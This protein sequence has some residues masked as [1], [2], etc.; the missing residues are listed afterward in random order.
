MS[1]YI[2]GGM[3]LL[4]QK[5][6][7]QKKNNCW[8][9]VYIKEGIGMYLLGTSLRTL[10]KGDMM[11]L[12]P[13]VYYSFES[14]DLGDEYNENIK[15]HVMRFDEDWLNDLIKVFPMM[16]AT[17]LRIKEIR[18]PLAVTGPKWMRIASLFE[19]SAGQPQTV[20]TLLDQ[21]ST[22]KDVIQIMDLDHHEDCDAVEARKAMI[23]RY[24]SCNL[25]SKVT[26][27]DVASYVGMNRIYF[28]MFFKTHYKENFTEYLNRRRVELS[29][30]LLS[31]STKDIPAIA[32]ECGFKTVPY[33]TRVFSKFMG[34]TPAKYRKYHIFANHKHIN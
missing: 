13:H 14:D 18:N 15:A 2:S 17:I 11:I 5:S 3:D 28:C 23:D 22:G 6:D 9:L 24:L 20:L 32:S 26:L 21:I 8:T 31:G 4:T 7:Y 33:F 29:C 25:C 1:R 19:N 12:P 10:N 30:R 27:E 16:S 34:I